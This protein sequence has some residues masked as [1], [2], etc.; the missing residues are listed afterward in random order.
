MIKYCL[1]FEIFEV[2][3]L[4]SNGIANGTLVVGSL[5]DLCVRGGSTVHCRSIVV[6][7]RLAVRDSIV[8]L[9]E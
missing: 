9:R 7:A 2:K 8:V 5:A 4:L 1:T 6:G 3:C